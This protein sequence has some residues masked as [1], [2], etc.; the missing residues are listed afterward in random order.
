MD[1]FVLSSPPASDAASPQP[2]DVENDFCPPSFR[3]L[4]PPTSN[5]LSISD[6]ESVRTNL[7]KKLTLDELKLMFN[8]HRLTMIN[9]EN[10]SPSVDLESLAKQ[11]LTK[12]RLNADK[13][14][15]LSVPPPLS[16]DLPSL[17]HVKMAISEKK[18]LVLPVGTG[19]LGILANDHFELDEFDDED[20]ED[21]EE[22]KNNSSMYNFM[23]AR[24]LQLIGGANRLLTKNDKLMFSEYVLR[25]SAGYGVTVAESLSLEVVRKML[26]PQFTCFAAKRKAHTVKSHIGNR[27]WSK[28][29]VTLG[30]ALEVRCRIVVCYTPNKEE[31]NE[32]NEHEFKVGDA[33]V[34]VVQGFPLE[35]NEVKSRT[36]DDTSFVDT[37]ADINFVPKLPSIMQDPQQSYMTIKLTPHLGEDSD[38]DFEEEEEENQRRNLTNTLADQETEATTANIPNDDDNNNNNANDIPDD[39]SVNSLNSLISGSSASTSMKQP[40]F[41]LVA[42]LAIGPDFDSDRPQ[43]G[44]ASEMFVW[45]DNDCSC[46]GIPPSPVT[47][48]SAEVIFTPQTVPIGIMSEKVK[49][50]SCS[51]HHSIVCSMIGAV[52]TC[53]D[54]SDG[55]LGHGIMKSVLQLTLVSAFA[56]MVPPPVITLV[57]AGS[58][59]SG[60]HSAAVDAEGKLYTWGK[61]SACGHIG[62]AASLSTT[63]AAPL[64]SFFSNG[65]SGNPTGPVVFPRQVTAFKKR[66]VL[67]VSC[68]G[69][70]TLA[71]ACLPSKTNIDNTK[72]AVYSWGLWAGGRLGLGTAPSKVDSTYLHANTRRKIP[73]FQPRPRRITA[74]DGKHVLNV[75][76]GE[77]HSMAVTSKGEVYTWGQ[78]DAGQCGIVPVHPDV[79]AAS[80]KR[81]LEA[82]GKGQAPP[83]AATV[84]DDVLRPRLC[85]PF[86]QGRVF[87]T[88]A[89][90]GG[91]HSAVI[92]ANGKVWTWGG[93]GH[94]ACLGHGECSDE[95]LAPKVEG[96]LGASAAAAREGKK[97]SSLI[98]PKWGTPRKV[99]ALQAWKVEKVSLGEAHCAVVTTN[100]ALLSWGGGVGSVKVKEGVDE[101]KVKATDNVEDIIEPVCVP[102]EPCTS[103]LSSMS[104][105][106][107]SD[108][109]CG[110]Q[111]S[112]AIATGEQIG[113]GLGRKLL[114]ACG[115]TKKLVEEEDSE[116]D[117]DIEREGDDS[118]D[119]FDDNTSWG[120]GSSMFS[121]RTSL[122]S[123]GATA[124]CVML[125]AGRRLYAH[126]VILSKRCAKLRDMIYEEHRPDQETMCELILPDLRFDVARCLLQFIY[127]DDVTYA[128][129]PTTTL[130]FDLLKAGEEYGLP[131]LVALCKVA[132]ALR[133]NRDDD[134]VEEEEEEDEDSYARRVRRREEEQEEI[135]IPASRLPIDLGGA[136]GESEWADIK[137]MANGKPIYAHRC[138]LSARSTYFS[139]MFRSGGLDGNRGEV[140]EVQVPDSYVGLLRVLVWIYCGNLA[141]SNS[142]ALL[143]DMLAADRYALFD[144]K[145]TCESM[146]VVTTEN[147]ASVLDVACTVNAERLKVESMSVLVRNL[148]DCTEPD[149]GDSLR[150]LATRV[151]D[152]MPTLM[153]MIV[154]KEHHRR[155]VMG[156][157]NEVEQLVVEVGLAGG[158]D[159]NV[160]D[161]VKET[162]RKGLKKKKEREAEAAKGMTGGEVKGPIPLSFLI[163]MT[164]CFIAY[165]FVGKMI[166]L[167]PLVPIV[168]TIFF[169]FFVVKLC[170]GLKN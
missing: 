85:P 123:Q 81:I 101:S 132:T 75:S 168:N 4:F 73:R 39:Q 120:A 112:M 34:I 3:P 24:L 52:Y 126:K 77:C 23:N 7:S 104:G 70:Y 1:G 157:V 18:V 115:L 141:E 125:V 108:I 149:G 144:M 57:S 35:L 55:Q 48:L 67:K 36:S 84:W 80:G 59:T 117:S 133:P 21:D 50:I 46:L 2:Y 32:A 22:N 131:R 65:G 42:S 82:L 49:S 79:S 94:G 150:E 163:M 100:G 143:E 61:A 5:T 89:V 72:T 20:N 97:E 142:D 151:P 103:W 136:L 45:G 54:G 156:G 64:S 58:H 56:S 166:V 124:D 11:S 38:Q 155:G 127:T 164:A 146:I 95:A 162:L 154:E 12:L 170:A 159:L 78:N 41:D 74:L 153:D 13:L 152:V 111:H 14:S 135:V 25:L 43:R 19:D 29:G 51:A 106:I 71:I 107:V 128:L 87:A 88:S 26:G 169:A 86:V 69:G 122:M 99:E 93:G 33:V 158:R 140:V 116:E 161:D 8:A 31:V 28:N 98:A 145:R 102:R 92:D 134:L 119:G 167:G 114:R 10:A 129:D 110:G 96:M 66:P 60:S 165:T 47:G 44:I 9:D 130:P 147:A 27:N 62:S 17:D 6:F 91:L 15:S 16:F 53:G 109:S 118:D 37:D 138:I 121:T 160:T 30:C 90:A 68:G 105:K 139:A 113:M 137:F 63:S 76:A 40:L 148:V 83:T